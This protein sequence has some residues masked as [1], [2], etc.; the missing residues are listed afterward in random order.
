[1]KNKIYYRLTLFVITA[2]FWLVSP[3][4]VRADCYSIPFSYYSEGGCQEVR[5]ASQSTTCGSGYFPYYSCNGPGGGY[6]TWTYCYGCRAVGSSGGE[7]SSECRA[8]SSCGTGYTGAAGCSGTG[9]NF[10]CKSNQVCCKSTGSCGGGGG[11]E[12]PGSCPAGQ[13]P[14]GDPA[15]ANSNPPYTSC[16]R[17]GCFPPHIW[18]SPTSEP[19]GQNK[20]GQ[21]KWYCYRIA[22]CTLGQPAAPVLS[23][24][25]DGAQIT[26]LSTTL[27]WTYPGPWGDACNGTNQF[28]VRLGTSP[29]NVPVVATVGSGTFSYLANNLT[30]G[31]TYY[32]RIVATH[33]GQGTSS[34]LWSFTVANNR[35]QGTVYNDADG[36]CSTA[37]P[38]NLGAS[39]TA[40]WG[41]SNTAAVAANGTFAI[42]TTVGIPNPQSL[43]ITGYPSSYICSPA[44]G[45][46]P[47][48]SGIN[49]PSTGN[50]FFFTQQRVG[51]W[52]AVGAGVYAGEGGAGVTV[53]S[54]LPTA[55]SRLIVPGTN[56]VGALVRAS[57]GQ[58]SLGAGQLSTTGWK[59]V[60]EYDGKRMDYAFFAPHIGITSSTTDDLPGTSLAEPTYDAN[61]DFWYQNG[62]ASIDSP[63]TITGT[64]KFVV[65][66]NGDLT[67]NSD[68]TVASTGFLAFIVN[69]NVTVGTGVANLQGLYVIDDLFVTNTADPADDIALAVQGSVIAWGG[70][71][72]NRDLGPTNLT[73]PAERFT[74]RPDLIVTMPDK[75]KIFALRW[76]EVAPG[77]FPN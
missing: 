68:I 34:P 18:Q 26:S 42:T 4:L 73:T 23:S 45:N 77:T 75:M 61:K 56:S 57:S 2:L 39:L 10:G 38:S 25:A 50:N 72:L 66:V 17:A 51:W 64:D 48:R 27:S 44:C 40:R 65:F 31:T 19:C 21:D 1:M 33:S 37:N 35:V 11:G 52:Q 14:I 74:Y 28:E 16:Q 47:T 46:C 58:P 20:F 12:E 71:D 67:I 13:I 43:S 55:A 9:P 54:T 24:P 59:A 6:G 32:W 36:T 8:G 7:C 3:R 29:S 60:S 5:N 76:Q 22:C 49:S 62:S 53:R 70:V 15:Y 63:W 69:G 41:A 30:S